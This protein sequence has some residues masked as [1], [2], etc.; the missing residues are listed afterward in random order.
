MKLSYEERVQGSFI[1]C[2]YVFLEDYGW[3]FKRSWEEAVNHTAECFGI[4]AEEVE[5]L[6]DE[7]RE[8]IYNF[9]FS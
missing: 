6:V 5:E 2:F 8:H 7:M 3:S 9:D 1:Q 4:T